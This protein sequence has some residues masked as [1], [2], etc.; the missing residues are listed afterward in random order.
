MALKQTS[1]PATEPVT[2]EEIKLHLR[3]DTED[4]DD[5]LTARITAARVF[6]EEFQRRG[7]ITQ[8]WEL[9]LDAW[10]DKGYIEIPLP[11]LQSVTSVKYYDTDDTEATFSSDCYFV[12][13]KSESGR[14]GLNYGEVWPSTTLRPMN[15]ICVTF[16]AGYGDADDVPES[17]KQAML[18]L[19][20][21]W[22]ENRETVI[23]S[24]AMPKEMPFSV[25]ALLWQDRIF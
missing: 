7:F 22:Y 9:W 15:G 16:K 11:P 10:P 2:L 20:A 4:E 23:S 19:I 13:S 24:G 14:I 1:A 18:L 8:T 3:V 17:V 6:C 12:D 5:W 25:E 21:H